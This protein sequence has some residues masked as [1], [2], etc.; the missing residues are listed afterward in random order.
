MLKS[1]E[2][3][4]N[5]TSALFLF[6]ILLNLKQKYSVLFFFL[7]KRF[8]LDKKMSHIKNFIKI[9]WIQKCKFFF[10]FERYL[11]LISFKY[12]SPDTGTSACTDL[13]K[14]ILEYFT[15]IKD[16][17]KESQLL[18]KKERQQN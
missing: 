2:G 4:R 16:C 1:R 12:S 7:N 11:G 14:I 18:P 8:I 6:T 9:V 5:Q 17:R 15:G 13:V 10:L 3:A